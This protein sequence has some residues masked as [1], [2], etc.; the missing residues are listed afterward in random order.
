MLSGLTFDPDGNMVLGIRDR[1]ADQNGYFQLSNPGSGTRIEGSLIENPYLASL[2]LSDGFLDQRL[3][4]LAG[5]QFHRM[6][7][8][9]EF[10]WAHPNL[11]AWAEA[12]L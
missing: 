6:G 10:E 4:K 9:F 2:G 3:S 8:L 5:I 11:S 7:R 12:T 1:G